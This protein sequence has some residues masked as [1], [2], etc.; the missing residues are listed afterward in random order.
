MVVI[1]V[2]QAFERRAFDAKER[3]VKDSKDEKRNFGVL[4]MEERAVCRLA[5]FRSLASPSFM[6]NTRYQ[7]PFIT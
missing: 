3:V 6:T 2:N 1:T 7:L 5:P 4:Q